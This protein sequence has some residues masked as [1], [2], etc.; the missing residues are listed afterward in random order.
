MKLFYAITDRLKK[1]TRLITLDITDNFIETIEV[2]I[3]KQAGKMQ[4][5]FLSK[6]KLKKVDKIF[7]GELWQLKI[8]F[9][10]ITGK[11][12]ISGTKWLNRVT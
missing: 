5:L 9:Y 3:F 2:G 8:S 1:Y 6:N 12:N 11:L 7:Q 10:F 4:Q